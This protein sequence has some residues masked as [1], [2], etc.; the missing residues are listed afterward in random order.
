MKEFNCKKCYYNDYCMGEFTCPDYT[1]ANS[2][3]VDTYIDYLIEKERDA[4][5]SDFFRYIDSFE[6]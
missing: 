1:D 5:R 4:F 3:A 2:E 6:D